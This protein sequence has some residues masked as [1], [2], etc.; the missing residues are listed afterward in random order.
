M[1]LKCNSILHMHGQNRFR[2]ESTSQLP[3]VYLLEPAAKRRRECRKYAYTPAW[4]AV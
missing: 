1:L 3:E 4:V 2:V